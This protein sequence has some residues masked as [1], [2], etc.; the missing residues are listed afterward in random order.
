MIAC[1]TGQKV[2]I[3]LTESDDLIVFATCSK[4]V[5]IMEI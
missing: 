3:R 4:A 5:L 2:S 1:A